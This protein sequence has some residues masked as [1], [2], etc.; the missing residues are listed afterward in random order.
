M[1]GIC[2]GDESKNQDADDVREM[3]NRLPKE[4]IPAQSG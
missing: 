4:D 3:K 1:K 2:D